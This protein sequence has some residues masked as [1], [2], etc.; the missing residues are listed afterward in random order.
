M[1]SK[2]D[3][4]KSIPQGT[5]YTIS[6]IGYYNY[7]YPSDESVFR[8]FLSESVS[9]L[10][11]HWKGGGTEWVAYQVT[12]DVAKRYGSPIKVLWFAKE[13]LKNG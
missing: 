9:A 2:F 4:I 7:W 6:E 8:G 3:D 12:A 11:L 1:F 10:D 13:D 5:R